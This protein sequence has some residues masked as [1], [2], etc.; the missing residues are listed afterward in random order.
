MMQ[1]AQT[2]CSVTTRE[3]WDVV[4]EGGAYVY[5]WLTHVDAWQKPIQ[6]CEVI[7]LQLKINKSNSC[8]G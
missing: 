7:I 8:L 3:G 5:L 1:G 2:W 6:Y 4:Q